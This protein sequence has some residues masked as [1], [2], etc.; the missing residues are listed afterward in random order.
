MFELLSLYLEFIE[1]EKGLSPNSIEAY[2]RDVEFF[3]E[4][5]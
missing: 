4:Y 2:R 5:F 1:L 3:L